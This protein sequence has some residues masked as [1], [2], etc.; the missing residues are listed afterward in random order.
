[1]I[2]RGKPPEMSLLSLAHR[3]FAERDL[4][5]AEGFKNAVQ[6]PKIEVKR[7]QD[8]P[9]L[10][11]QVEGV[12]AVATDLLPAGGMV[13]G[14][15][16]GQEIADLIEARFLQCPKIAAQVTLTV[17][18]ITLALPEPIPDQLVATVQALLAP[19][20]PSLPQGTRELTIRLCPSPEASS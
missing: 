13:F 14:L 9:W 11:D 5:I 3:Y 4:V 1:L 19:L 15:D 16:Q 18:G 7:D 2:I 8:A 17:N 10:R 20:E 6:V 12:I